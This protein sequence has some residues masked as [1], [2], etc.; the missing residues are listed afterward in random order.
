MGVTSANRAEDGVHEAQ[1]VSLVE[2]TYH[3]KIVLF[4]LLI[5]A[6][7]SILSGWGG[8]WPFSD[9]VRQRRA[10]KGTACSR[11]P[12]VETFSNLSLGIPEHDEIHLVLFLPLGIFRINHGHILKLHLFFF[13]L[14]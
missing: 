3:V 1:E 6:G 13:L 5:A 4:V 10:V 14:R 8:G 12:A 11:L 9:C 2:T 7:R